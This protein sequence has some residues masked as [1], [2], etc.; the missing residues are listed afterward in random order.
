MR[1][2]AFTLTPASK[3][4]RSASE[5]QIIEIS[6]ALPLGANEM[7]S[8][9]LARGRPA[10]RVTLRTRPPL[11]PHINTSQP[12]L[13]RL[14]FCFPKACL[15]LPSLVSFYRPFDLSRHCHLV[16]TQH[17][18]DLHPSRES[19]HMLILSHSV[20]VTGFPDPLAQ[21]Q[22]GNDNSPGLRGPIRSLLPKSHPRGNESLSQPPSGLLTAPRLRHLAD[23]P[24]AVR[25]L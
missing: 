11:L 6:L 12:S 23:P 10:L 9:P 3:T 2:G 25:T 8:G 15:W 22:A 4:C 16:R 14:D 24:G 5:C 1:L 13:V 21:G 20:P 19:R 18:V 17:V 7:R